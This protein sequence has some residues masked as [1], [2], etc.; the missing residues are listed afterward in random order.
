M[1]R[2]LTSRVSSRSQSSKSLYNAHSVHFIRFFWFCC[3]S[4]VE[5]DRGDIFGQSALLSRSR[6]RRLVMRRS[7]R[8]GRSKQDT[9]DVCEG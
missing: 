9:D 1:Q 6:R 3:A 2:L 4:L 8:A 7:A 5:K